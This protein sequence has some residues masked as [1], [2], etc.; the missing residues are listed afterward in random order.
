[1]RACALQTLAL[2]AST[3]GIG[4][5]LTLTIFSIPQASSH[6]DLLAWSLQD[7]TLHSSVAHQQAELSAHEPGYSKMKSY[8]PASIAQ[9]T[10]C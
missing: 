2:V 6:P 10:T 9:P 1:M 8:V 7:P 5:A 4:T 3:C